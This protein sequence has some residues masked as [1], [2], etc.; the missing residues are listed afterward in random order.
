MCFIYFMFLYHGF[1][2]ILSEYILYYV[3]CQ[4][5]FYAEGHNIIFCPHALL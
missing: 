1:I 2:F 5:L 3:L 4:I